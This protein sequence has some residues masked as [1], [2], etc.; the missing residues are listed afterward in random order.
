MRVVDATTKELYSEEGP[1]MKDHEVIQP[2]VDLP[3]PEQW[4]LRVH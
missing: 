4:E 3:A 1:K 2:K